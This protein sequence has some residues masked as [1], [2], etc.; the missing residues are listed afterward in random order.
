MMRRRFLLDAC[1]SVAAALWPAGLLARPRGAPQALLVL[2]QEGLGTAAV[3]AAGPVEVRQFSARAFVQAP[4]LVNAGGRRVL[5]IVS[6]AN[7]VL[8]VDAVRWSGGRLH[9]AGPDP[10]AAWR[11]AQLGGRAPHG[12]ATRGAHLVVASL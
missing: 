1:A 11:A 2:L 5:G 6:G 12:L 4:L 7:S 10:S 9:Y 3:L 8:L